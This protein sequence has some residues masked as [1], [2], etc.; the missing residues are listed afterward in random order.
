MWCCAIQNLY[1]SCSTA[2][3]LGNMR[4][5][6]ILKRILKC[7][8]LMLIGILLRAT[9]MEINWQYEYPGWSKTVNITGTPIT[10]ERTPDMI[11]KSRGID[12]NIDFFKAL[13]YSHVHDRYVQLCLFRLASQGLLTK[14]LPY[15][16]ASYKVHVMYIK[17]NGCFCIQNNIFFFPVIKL[18]FISNIFISNLFQSLCIISFWLHNSHRSIILI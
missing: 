13:G 4:F 16:D 17:Y 8:F 9:L 7:A 3:D 1:K 6:R 12:S 11:L 5:L 14:F 10:F 15:N 2:L 18:F